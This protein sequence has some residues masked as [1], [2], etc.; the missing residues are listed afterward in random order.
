[1]FCFA[2]RAFSPGTQLR[3]L[4]RGGRCLVSQTIWDHTA[5]LYPP[6]RK[7]HTGNGLPASPARGISAVT[8]GLTS[9][10]CI[11]EEILF[12]ARFRQVEYNHNY[13]G[14]LPQSNFFL[15][16]E[17]RRKPGLSSDPGFFDRRALQSA[18]VHWRSSEFPQARRTM[19][20]LVIL[21]TAQIVL[22]LVSAIGMQ[23]FDQPADS[24]CLRSTGPSRSSRWCGY[25]ALGVPGAQPPRR[26]RHLAA[27][28]AGRRGA[29]A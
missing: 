16:H 11:L 15:S 3:A 21:L 29:G 25:L 12:P 24:S 22:F 10:S 8:S 17:T 28:P 14:R 18:Y 5:T 23:E 9:R 13:H 2:P 1:M 27:E 6:S 7:P 4:R 26:C 19:F 20:G